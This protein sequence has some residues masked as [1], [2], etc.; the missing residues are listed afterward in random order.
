[1][2][3]TGK[4][5][6]TGFMEMLYKLKLSDVTEQPYCFNCGMLNFNH[7]TT[8]FCSQLCKNLFLD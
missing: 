1:M 4:E 7:R 5:L 3:I 6:V 2:K 8:N